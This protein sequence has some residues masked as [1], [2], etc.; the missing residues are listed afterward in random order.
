MASGMG[1]A[2]TPAC[3]GLSQ[4]RQRRMRV[5]HIVHIRTDRTGRR[6]SHRVTRVVLQFAASR[7]PGRVCLGHA[8]DALESVQLV[9]QLQRL[10]IA[11]RSVRRLCKASWCASVHS[12]LLR[13]T[14]GV[15]PGAQMRLTA[16]CERC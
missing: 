1:I 4:R 16:L 3:A 5:A 8:E 11:S 15:V 12:R 9:A 2:G 7:V 13:R 6:E 14:Y 10:E